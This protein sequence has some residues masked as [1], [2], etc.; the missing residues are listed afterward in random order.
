M[1]CSFAR[2]AAKRKKVGQMVVS[3]TR[4][5]EITEREG[6]RM[7]AARKDGL[8]KPDWDATDGTVD[9]SETTQVIVGG[10]GVTVPVITAAEKATRRAGRKHVRRRGV[11][12]SRRRPRL[13]G[14]DQ[15]WKELKIGQFYSA[16]KDYGWAFATRGN[17]GESGRQLRREATKI[18]R[19]QADQTFSVTD[20]AEWLRRQMRTRLPML[21]E[22]ILDFFHFAPHVADTAAICFGPETPQTETWTSTRRHTAKHDG[23]LPGLKQIDPTRSTLRSQPKR[24]S[25]SS[26]VAKS[27]G[28]KPFY[29][30]PRP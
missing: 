27:N 9:G 10:D 12:K 13:R 8:L 16:D 14:A 7:L 18:T 3:C 15:G 30:C 2:A 11:K 29:R 22:R 25:S 17:A 23:P 28:S 21:E 20:G 5:R 4:M 1:D 6:V 26:G 19:S 24:K